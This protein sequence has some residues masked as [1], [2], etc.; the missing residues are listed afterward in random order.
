M[1]T[2][3]AQILDLA[4]AALNTDRPTGIPVAT[5]VRLEP[6]EDQEA[7]AI[8]VYIGAESVEPA[9]NRHGPLVKRELELVVECR[10][11]GDTPDVLLDPLVDWTSR[12]LTGLES[13]LFHDIQEAGTDFRFELSGYLYGLAVQRFRVLYQTQRADPS[14]RA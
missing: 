8:A 4:L 6:L 11:V 13:T 1:A 2:I 7:P 12:T 3:R 9:T 5:R 10:V 14:L